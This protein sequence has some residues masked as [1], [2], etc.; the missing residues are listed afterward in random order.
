MSH[1]PLKR[2]L[3]TVLTEVNNLLG[4]LSPSLS[5]DGAS[6]RIS[7]ALSSAQGKVVAMGGEVKAKAQEAVKVTDTYVH[8]RPWQAVGIGAA[9]GLIIG[10]L[11]ARR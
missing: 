9:A 8:E 11:A 2:D 5:N 10:L 3:E 7:Q 6:A 1:T 4:S